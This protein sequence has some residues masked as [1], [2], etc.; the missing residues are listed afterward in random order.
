MTK[1]GK[2]VNVLVIS[3]S[4]PSNSDEF[5]GTFIGR[6]V[7]CLSEK[8]Y[9]MV[10]LT[11]HTYGDDLI[12][13]QGSIKVIR[14]PYFFPLSLQRLS[15]SGG[16]YFGFKS[17]LSGKLQT[18]SYT[19]I[20]LIY[21]GI[22]I[23]REKI[24][25]IHTHWVIPQGFVG[26]FWKV[27]TGIPHIATSHVLDLTISDE[28]KILKPVLRWTLR[29]SDAITVNSSF[30]LKQALRFAPPFI[31]NYIIPMGFDDSRIHGASEGFTPQKKAN[32][33][34]FV[35]RLI[36]WKGVDFLI[37]AIHIVKSQI[38]SVSLNIVGDGP[39][40]QKF[41]SLVKDLQ[42]E[43]N[44]RFMGKVTD[45]ELN[46]AYLGSTLF[47]LPSTERKGFVMEGLGVVLLEA[48]AS[49]VPVIGS[50]TGGIPDIIKDG[51]NGLLVQPGDPKA[52]ADAIIRIL[53]DQALADRFR[54]A[55]I[56]TVSERFSWDRIGDQFTTV[57][58][59]VLHE[60]RRS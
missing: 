55:G 59:E 48:M 13:S 16:M 7:K 52:L 51:V 53:N 8:G 57:Y 24:S 23:R 18:I 49:G 50:N 25:I 34:L 10:I 30:T 38:P 22:I 4:Y 60:S 14:F 58:Q 27:V 56:K 39:E 44:V 40:R 32:S 33:V 47:V 3:S 28:I 17:S 2:T 26:A 20:M 11:P 29:H 12:I 37:Q 19:I 31:K 54:E 42:L 1:N 41:E 43:N 15:S 36:D 6:L 45:A 35:G 5:R 9:N 46:Q 21:S